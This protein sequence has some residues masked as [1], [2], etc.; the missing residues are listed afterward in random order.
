MKT[1]LDLQLS[2]PS[3]DELTSRK[4]MGGDGY[5]PENDL[6]N[7]LPKF[8]IDDMVEIVIGDDVLI[9]GNYPEV[10]NAPTTEYDIP[11]PDMNPI[12]IERPENNEKPEFDDDRNELHESHN[13]NQQGDYDPEVD[14]DHKNNNSS[15]TN[16]GGDSRYDKIF[17]AFNSIKELSTN[18]F[19]LTVGGNVE[20]NIKNDPNFANTCAMRLSYA[21]NQAGYTIPHIVDKTI[22]GD[23][24]G[25]GVKEWYFYRV[26][27]I[28]NFLITTFGQGESY[29]TDDLSGIQGRTGIICYGDCNFGDATGHVDLWDGDSVVRQGYD[30]RCNSV[31]FWDI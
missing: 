27:D 26:S 13:G 12:E 5:I 11:E 10:P 8:E 4:L 16:E 20:Y 15:S 7:A 29:N 18:Q 28:T 19:A 17:D 30:G 3:L 24:D 25:D 23:T 2:I 21:L 22:S 1:L 31:T 9:T 14:Q 6:S